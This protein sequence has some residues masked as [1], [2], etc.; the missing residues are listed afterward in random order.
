L[1]PIKLALLWHQHQPDYRAGERMALPWV[2]L[3][4]T[5]DYLEMAQ[6]LERYPKMRATI[7]LVPILIKQIEAYQDGIEDDLLHI[8]KKETNSLTA[9]ERTLLLSEC[10]HANYSRVISRST[11]YTELYQKK[12]RGETFTNDELRDLT[13]HY[14]LAWTGEFVREEEP[15]KSLLAKDRDYSE[16]DKT[17]FL[18]AQ[19]RV[20]DRILPLHISLFEKGQIEVSTTPYYHPILPL[21]CDTDSAKETVPNVPLPH[22]RFSNKDDAYEQVRRGKEVFEE[23]FGSSP[24][25]MWPSEGSISDEALKVLADENISWTASDEAVLGNSLRH[26]NTEHD[27]KKY[28]E[29]EKFFPRKFAS[30]A[31]EIVIFFRDHI[32]SDMIGFEYSTWDAR[33]AAVNFLE[34]CKTIR[35]SLIER[36]GEESLKTACI[37]VILDG[38]N[39]WES[40]PE[41]GKYF[42]NEFYTALTTTAEIEPVTF[43]QALTEIGKENIRPL[44]HVVAGSW[45]YG[46]FKIWIGEPEK[47]RA[48]DLLG[49]AREALHK[50]DPQTSET[51]EYYDAAHTSLLK[52]EGSDWFW[53]Y[54][55]DNA[56]AQKQVFDELF[57][58]H[59]LEMYIHLRL[60]VPRELL[61]PV[62]KYE[63]LSDGGSMH[64]AA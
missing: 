6:H 30:G 51:Q 28:Q 58:L 35:T 45:V 46:N 9:K 22:K 47:N 11:R 7:N 62:G 14:G 63:S 26:P 50:Y 31:N 20:I 36:F 19:E 43:S 54:D 41:N 27:D 59:I 57:R 2:R 53:W 52:A 49:E 25:G 1:I 48:W 12:N 16:K 56:S 23:R 17:E 37:S 34:H 13:I 3:H 18:L 29:L 55:D 40:Y 24:K 4:A 38:E 33:D 42:L 44:S 15:F 39:C 5:K 10:F 60:P 61:Q 32:L 64:K 8:E 21:I